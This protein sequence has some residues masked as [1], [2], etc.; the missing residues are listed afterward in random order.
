MATGGG[1]LTPYK[2]EST[3]TAPPRTD[4]AQLREMIGV[5]KATLETMYVS[6][7][8]L[9]WPRTLI[10]LCDVEDSSFVSCKSSKLRSQMLGQPWYVNDLL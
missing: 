10:S 9:E 5:T 2:R 4:A 6:L 3:I 8:I 7:R 1:A